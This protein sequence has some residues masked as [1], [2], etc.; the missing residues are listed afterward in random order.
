M[1]WWWIPIFLTISSVVKKSDTHASV[2]CAEHN[3]SFQHLKGMTQAFLGNSQLVTYLSPWQASE[4]HLE[5]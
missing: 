4:G 3:T 5:R 2:F 1:D